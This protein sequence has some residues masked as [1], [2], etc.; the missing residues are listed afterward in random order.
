MIGGEILLGFEDD[1]DRSLVL[2]G[3]IN[4]LA[5]ERDVELVLDLEP[6]A[7][8]A[9]VGG[10]SFLGGTGFGFSAT[11]D[12]S[13]FLSLT[14]GRFGSFSIA[15]VFDAL[16]LDSINGAGIL[17]FEL[18][19]FGDLLFNSLDI[20]LNLSDEVSA[21]VP[22]PETL[23]LLMSALLMLIVLRRRPLVPSDIV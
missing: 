7:V 23:M 18:M 10:S 17:D 11:S 8:I 20:V 1:V 14:L 6:E 22:E 4:G 19:V 5:D 21:S 12:A 16:V 3:R 9:N 2:T 13:G 15:G